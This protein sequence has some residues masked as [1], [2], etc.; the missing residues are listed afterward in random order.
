MGWREHSEGLCVSVH[1]LD[2]FRWRPRFQKE[3][4]GVWVSRTRKHSS[5]RFSNLSLG[6]LIA[7]IFQHSGAYCNVE[8]QRF[9]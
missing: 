6:L 8:S 7:W 4:K 5:V 3:S 1:M 2:Q 9:S